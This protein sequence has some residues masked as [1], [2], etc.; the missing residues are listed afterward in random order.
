MIASFPFT[1]E[2]ALNCGR[3]FASMCAERSGHDCVY[4]SGG[5]GVCVWASICAKCTRR[6][7]KIRQDRA[8]VRAA[9]G[10]CRVAEVQG[11]KMRRKSHML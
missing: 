1:V 3:W 7:V 4:T 8:E 2:I 5:G 11:Y 10:T 6:A 9:Y